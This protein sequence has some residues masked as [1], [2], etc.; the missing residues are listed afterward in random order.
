[1]QN[2]RF[3]SAQA[4]GVFTGVHAMT[5]SFDTNHLDILVIKERVEQTDRV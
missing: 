4:G 2:A 5:G 3:S 1:M